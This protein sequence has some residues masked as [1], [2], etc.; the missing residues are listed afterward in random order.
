MATYKM[1]KCTKDK[2][3]FW[4]LD[5]NK[6][7]LFAYRHRYYD[8]FGR[9]KE[10]SARG[11]ANENTAFRELLRIKTEVA[12]GNTKLIENENLTIKQWAT[13]WLEAN[14]SNWKVSTNEQ[15]KNIVEQ[16]IIP[17]LGT[18]KLMKLDKETYINLYIK[19]LSQKYSVGTVKLYHRIFKVI[20]NGAVDAEIITRNRF[21]K[22]KIA[23]DEEPKDGVGDNVYTP[24]ELSAFLKCIND[25]ENITVQTVFALLAATG[26]RRG[27]VAALRWKDIDF[28]N[29]T[30]NIGR[31]RD[32][33]GERKAKTENSIRTLN[34]NESLIATLKKYKA[35]SKQYLLAN[36]RW[37]SEKEFEESFAIISYQTCEAISDTYISSSLR[38]V[39]KN[40]DLK[41]IT[42]HGFRHTFATILIN[43]GVPVTTI[44]KMLGNTTKMVMEVYSHSFEENEKRAAQ[45]IADVMKFA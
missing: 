2:E 4:Y 28:E 3:L 17:L 7:K 5:G 24:E 42:P 9:R 33:Y 29:S 26:M 25:Q 16:Q 32:R 19:P 41:E 11:F 38:R 15:R 13:K 45:V 8:S 1:N 20:I 18:Q 35:W 31:T 30:I 23:N 39:I 34:V 27:E 10:K 6:N 12:A 36:G 37:K 44:A 43:N 21:T 40:N 14:Q 22:I